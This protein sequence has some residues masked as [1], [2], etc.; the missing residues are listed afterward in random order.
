MGN[1]HLKDIASTGNPVNLGNSTAVA[2]WENSHISTR[3]PLADDASLVSD[4]GKELPCDFL[5]DL[6]IY[7]DGDPKSVKMTS[8][9]IGPALLSVSFSD[10]SGPICAATVLKSDYEQ[11]APVVLTPVAGRDVGGMCAFGIREDSM[12]EP[13]LFRFSKGVSVSL[14]S[15]FKLDTG[16]VMSFID[17]RNGEKLSGDIVISLGAGLAA[18]MDGVDDD[19]MTL[20]WPAAHIRMKPELRESVTSSC[21]EPENV[22]SD[23][24]KSPPIQA[25]NGVAPDCNGTLAIVFK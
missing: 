14:C 21:G 17:E 23:V 6:A 19:H 24:F 2:Q 5:V 22:E 4:G 9:Y 3:F 10:S 20:S 25:I 8:A 12:S 7:T 11:Y 16:R 13:S 15:C 18:Y 1:I